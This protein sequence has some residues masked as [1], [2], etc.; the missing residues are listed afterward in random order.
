MGQVRSAI[1]EVLG[2]PGPWQWVSPVTGHIQS[3][4]I[5]H[6]QSLLRL[7]SDYVRAARPQESHA[8]TV[9]DLA[10]LVPEPGKKSEQGNRFTLRARR[11]LAQ[12]HKEARSY[13]AEMVGTEHLLLALL[14]EQN[15]IAFHVL[16]NLEIDYDQ[17]LSAIQF[18]RIQ[19]NLREPE[20]Q[21]GFTEDGSKAVELAIDEARQ[22]YQSSIGSEHLL[23]GLSEARV[24]L[25]AY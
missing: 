3:Q 14:R 5:L 9:Q 19:E 18:L 23:L 4:G 7:A 2:Q 13:Q 17:I 11:V 20:G 24:L 8:S 21:D 6:T 1:L 10:D 22:L 12:A 25:L 15:G 16:H